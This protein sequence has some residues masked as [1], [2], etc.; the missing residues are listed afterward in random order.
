M[1]L[2]KINEDLT[3]EDIKTLKSKCL[4]ILNKTYCYGAQRY[5]YVS[6]D[7]R[8]KT[9]VFGQNSVE[10]K[11]LFNVIFNIIRDTMSLLKLKTYL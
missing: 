5:N 2:P 7:K 1:R 10:I 4:T 9:T 11:D 6:G 8:F 3:P